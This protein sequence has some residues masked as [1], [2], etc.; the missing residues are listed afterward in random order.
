MPRTMKIAAAQ[1]GP[2]HRDSTRQDTLSRLI[3][4]LQSASTLDA[5]L[6]LFPEAAFTT[7]FPRHLISDQTELDS[8][9]EHGD[10]L[11]GSPNTRPL[12]DE[13]KKLGIDISVGFAERTAGGKGYNT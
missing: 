11:P 4:L 9:F 13:A 2:V 12:F 6:V 3:K 1:M 7:F 8:F 5:Q 10:N